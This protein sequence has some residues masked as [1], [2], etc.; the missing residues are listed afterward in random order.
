MSTVQAWTVQIILFLLS[1][2]TEVLRPLARSASNA[3]IFTPMSDPSVIAFENGISIGNRM[4]MM[5]VILQ[6]CS[7][8]DLWD[9][10]LSDASEI[11]VSANTPRVLICGDDDGI[12]PLERCNGVKRALQISDECFHVVREAGHLPMIE[13]PNEVLQILKDMLF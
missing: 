13:K 6:D 8:Q 4:Y 1:F 11:L 7:D 12:F 5:K 10:W 9:T 2:L 3:A